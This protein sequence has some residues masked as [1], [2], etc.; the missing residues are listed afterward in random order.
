MAKVLPDPDCGGR[1][2]DSAF[3]RVRSCPMR[4]ERSVTLVTI[5]HVEADR[6]SAEAERR[7]HTLVEDEPMSRDEGMALAQSYCEHYCLPVIYER[8]DE[9]DFTDTVVMPELEPRRRSA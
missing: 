5:E 3:L 9:G 1:Y 6:S 7:C 8:H 2:T 4:R